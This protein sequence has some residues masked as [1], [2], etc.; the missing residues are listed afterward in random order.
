MRF[1]LPPQVPEQNSRASWRK[2]APRLT[3]TLPPLRGAILDGSAGLTYA[4]PQS[5]YEYLILI[6][7]KEFQ[8]R[9]LNNLPKKLLTDF[10]CSSQNDPIRP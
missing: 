10:Y 8:Q 2:A 7:T 6:K 9:S 3:W 4:T 5:F 1:N